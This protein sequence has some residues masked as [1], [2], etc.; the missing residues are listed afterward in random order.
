M[1]QGGL[2][3]PRCTPGAT[4]PDVTQADISSTICV[5][6]WSARQ[7]PP[8]S[9]TEPIKRAQMRAYGLDEP[10]G[11]VELD[12][13]VPL[14]LGGAPD[15]VAN[16]WPEPRAGP[17]GASRKDVLEGALHDLVCDQGLPLAQAQ[18]A[19]ATNWEAAYARWVG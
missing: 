14:E 17:E 8:E 9:V 18:Q 12:H 15:Q 10:L 11:D 4:D 6:G 5:P 19:I 3:D 13:L 2:P 16:L 1:G 7:R